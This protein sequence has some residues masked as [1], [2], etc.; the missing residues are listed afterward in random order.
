[1]FRVSFWN[2]YSRR[3]SRP[4][5]GEGRVWGRT[6]GG[7]LAALPACP[8]MWRWRV[9]GLLRAGE[10]QG[11][12]AA[13]RGAARALCGFRKPGGPSGAHGARGGGVGLTVERLRPGRY[14]GLGGIPGW[15]AVAWGDLETGKGRLRGSILPSRPCPTPPALSHSRDPLALSCRSRRR[16][17]SPGGAEEAGAAAG[18]Q[19]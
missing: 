1:M 13:L 16:R 12:S 4:D 9:P 18:L 8:A 10:G 17:R 2:S 5:H 19:R 3:V 6:N 7:A 11:G 14:R 15:A